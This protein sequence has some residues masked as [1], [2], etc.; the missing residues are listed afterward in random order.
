MYIVAEYLAK[1]IYAK[2]IVSGENLGQVASQ[3]LSN[4]VELS[5]AIEMPVF[6]PVLTYDKNQIMELA[7][8]I[9]TM[10]IYHEGDCEFVP[11]QPATSLTD[12]R[13]F[14]MNRIIDIQQEA[15]NFV[16]ENLDE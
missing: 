8:Y 11:S 3:T 1:K 13:R 4:L 15:E 16:K 12:K 6:R 10:D 5:S 9:G 7:R 2:G 14:E